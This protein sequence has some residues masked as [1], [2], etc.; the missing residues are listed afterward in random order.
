MSSLG[1]LLGSALAAQLSPHHTDTAPLQIMTAAFP[2]CVQLLANVIGLKDQLPH[3]SG[4]TALAGSLRNAAQGCVDGLQR[5]SSSSLT[6]SQQQPE[7]DIAVG[8]SSASTCQKVTCSNSSSAGSMSVVLEQ[9][10]P[11]CLVAAQDQEIRLSLMLSG[12]QQQQP[13]CQ[14]DDSGCQD[15]RQGTCDGRLLVF[16]DDGVLADEDVDLACSSIR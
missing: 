7:V 4:S 11:V 13:G 2:G 10:D 1:P 9:C 14:D 16:S 12:P 8:G 6:T 15:K 5:E 3:S